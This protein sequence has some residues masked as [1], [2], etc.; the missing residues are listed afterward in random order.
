MSDL[1]KTTAPSISGRTQKKSIVK[2]IIL[3]NFMSYEYSRIPIETGLNVIC[4]PNGAGKSSIL[5]AISVALG[6][7]YT[8]RSRKLS[9]LIR[10][11]KDVA[12]VSLVFDNAPREKGR[13]PVSFSRSDT[14]MLSRYLKKDGSYWHEGDFREM[15]KA[16]VVRLLR[17]FGI[18]PDNPLIIMHQGMVEEFS[19][20][21]PQEKLVMVEESVGFEKY[22]ANLLE[23]QRKLEGLVGEEVSTLQLMESANQTLDYWKEVY[24]R[25]LEKK[26][27]LEKKSHLERE[28]FWSQVVRHEK[29][30]EVAHEKLESRSRVLQNT[31]DKLKKASE[32][33]SG[34]WAHLL[35][36]RSELRGFYFSFARLE[37]EVGENRAG[38]KAS[39]AF[40][41]TLRERLKRAE[42]VLRKLGDGR[43]P[44]ALQVREHLET[45]QFIL[46]GYD[47]KAEES[48]RKTKDLEREAKEIQGE[49]GKSEESLTQLI[50]KHSDLKV[51]EAL[52][53][54]QK[55]NLEREVSEIKK[56]IVETERIL[57]ELLQQKP[58]GERVATERTPVEVGDEMKILAAQLHTL[59]DVPEEAETI[60]TNY[61]TIRKD[62]EEKLRT[63]RENK[64]MILREVEERKKVWTETLRRLVEE[65]SPE[66]QGILSQVSATGVVRLVNMDDVEG[67]GLELL[68][69]FRGASPTV[70]DAYTQS[71]GERSVAVMAFLLSLQNRIISPFRSIDEFDV[72]M[73]PRNREAMLKILFDQVGDEG[74]GQYLVITPSQLTV[75][76]K[77]VHLIF[78]Q[79]TQGASRAEVTKDAK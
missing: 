65:V 15:G 71:G 31:L 50:G 33:V 27:R 19:I 60:Y 4:G 40:S 59:G 45:L 7:T 63:L 68:V 72:H 43:T 44:E 32:A 37:K 11:G 17:Q 74:T 42:A 62:L 36:S 53:G 57:Q 56:S 23:A 76:D 51:S 29:S 48:G 18:N 66:Y 35:A 61:A 9:D 22:R 21:S 8:E 55:K 77:N 14:F 24:G 12:R 20:T 30:L 1:E 69:G 52:L 78:V 39:S 79:N 64:K 16:E 6:Q 25:Y 3:E 73:D 38:E 58:E 49:I 46:R 10:R 67:A 26:T 54:Y 75:L 34:A 13:R 41:E 70:L 47:S 28:L 2:E 5:L